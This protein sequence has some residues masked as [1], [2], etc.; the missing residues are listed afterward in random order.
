MKETKYAGTQTEKN[1][2][3]AFAGESEA[4]NKYTYFASK[5]KKEG[6]EQI[7]ALFLK[8]ADNEKEHAKLWFK[9]GIDLK[10]LEYVALASGLTK[11]QFAVSADHSRAAWQENTGIWDS[12]TIQIMD[13]DTGDKA[14]LGGQAGSVS[15][16]FGFVGN[17]CIYGTGDSGD[18]LMSNGR[19]MG[20]YLKSIDIVDREMKSVMHYE[21]PGS[22]I[23][24]VSVNDSRI[25][26]KTVTSKDGFFG[27]YSADT[28]V[29][30]AEIL[31]GKADDI[32]WYASDQKGQ[33]LFVQLDRDI[34]TA[35]KIR[36]L[37]RTRMR[38]N[39]CHRSAGP[40]PRRRGPAQRPGKTSRV[41]YP[42]RTPYQSLHRKTDPSPA[43]WR[44]AVLPVPSFSW[45]PPLLL[46]P[47]GDRR[48]RC[49]L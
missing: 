22:W 43:P 23:R 13:L 45:L 19:V 4:R 6:Y 2:M 1:L 7:A 46:I 44:Q 47:R 48:N 25:H 26:M 18:Y 27:T 16:I 17:D 34:E 15:R 8:T 14:Q 29:C 10:S 31:P 40:Y 35:K 38:R 24:E 9:E 11:A 42:R 32:G 39:S 5:A 41:D 49:R 33:V 28:L 37:R 3:V 21:K 20:V 36:R 12:Q 30:N